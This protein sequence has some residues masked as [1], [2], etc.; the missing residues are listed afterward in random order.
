MNAL[1]V[2]WKFGWNLRL[3]VV[4]LSES[5]LPGGGILS[6]IHKKFLKYNYSRAI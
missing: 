3:V 1:D 4:G 6:P 5:G 2:L